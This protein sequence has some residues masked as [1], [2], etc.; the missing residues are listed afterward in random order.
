[1][2]RWVSLPEKTVV[3][4]NCTAVTLHRVLFPQCSSTSS[5]RSAVLPPPGVGRSGQGSRNA[6]VKI[7]KNTPASE[8]RGVGSSSFS[9]LLWRTPFI[10]A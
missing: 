7:E 4:S 6:E 5:R 3:T 10:I 2:A 9:M 8:L 1:M